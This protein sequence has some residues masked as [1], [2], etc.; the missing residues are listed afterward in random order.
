MSQDQGSQGSDAAS[1]ELFTFSLYHYTPSLPAAILSVAIFAILT[2]THGWRMHRAGS[3]YFT[4][5]T[6][7]GLCMY[8]SQHAYPTPSGIDRYIGECLH[9][10]FTTVEVLGYA[11]RIWSHY[12][13][14]AIGGFVIQA[15]LILVAPALY[16]AS[17]YMILG[18][19]IRTMNAQHL[20]IIPV[21]RL[22][23]IFV[24]GDVVSFTLQAGGGGIQA[25]GTLDLYNIGEKIIIVGLFVQ[26]A[27]FSMFVAVSVTCYVRLRASDPPLAAVVENRIPWKRHL[28]ALFATSVLILVRSVFRVVEYLQGN[29]GYLISHE[30]FLYIFDMA[31]MVAVMVI[32]A[33]WYIDDLQGKNMYGKP[34]QSYSSDANDEEQQTIILQD[35]RQA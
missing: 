3:L 35:L 5:F 15:I 9:C 31:L 10:Y 11:G 20:S 25:A 34:L 18:R 21:N 33:I 22:T 14:L 17:I 2:A 26:I 32:F 28:Y 29:G 13:P 24:T 8:I 27:L 1:S 7:G 4:P 23:R 16:A 30:A 19:L 6:I 12:D